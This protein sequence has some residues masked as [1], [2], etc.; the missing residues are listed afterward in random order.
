MPR[1]Q[2]NKEYNTFVQGLITEASP[3]TFPE[4]ASKDEA[5]FILNRNGSRRRRQGMDYESSYSL[6]PAIDN[7]VFTDKYTTNHVWR[8]AANSG[9]N[10]FSVV[11]AGDTLYFYDLNQSALSFNRK[12][13]TVDLNTYK[14]TSATN[15]GSNPIFT[16]SGKGILFV[17][18]QD[19]EPF[20]IEY[21]PVAD[22]IS[23]AQINIK[24]RDFLGIDDGL[25]DD[26]NPS[27][28]LSA[29][30]NY[31]L[32][33]QGWTS[34]HITTY[35]TATSTSPSNSQVWWNGKNS[36]GVFNATD[37]DEIYF[38]NT[39][40]PKGHFIIDLFNRDRDTVS[41]VTGVTT[42]TEN[43]R[44]SAVAFYAGRAFYSGIQS[45]QDG[46]PSLNGYILFS[47]IIEDVDKIG[48]CYQS[49]DPTSEVV[50]DLIATDGGV[51]VIPEVGIIKR[52]EPVRDSLVI[53][54]DNGVWQLKGDTDAG[55]TADA[56]NVTKITNIG[57]INSQSIVT[58][59][60]TVFYWS[61][62]GIYALAPDNVTGYLRA[63]N[64]TETTI[65]SLYQTI[66][67]A[68]R[69]NCTGVYDPISKR[70]SWLY[71][72]NS[73]YVGGSEV[74]KYN[75]ELVFDVVLQAF[76]K[77]TISSLA[78]RS[79][80][81]AGYVLTPNLIRSDISYN[82]VDESGNLITDESLV[83]V[84]VDV[85][86]PTIGSTSIKYLT[87]VPQSD[88]TNSKLTYSLYTNSD[89]YDWKTA[90]NTGVNFV[91]YLWTGHELLQDSQRSKQITYL[92]THFTRTETGFTTSGTDLVLENPSGCY[93]Q[94]RWEF[95]DSENSGRW[96]SKLQAYRFNRNYI[97][98]GSGDTFD[99]GF[100]VIT[101]KNK[102]RGHGRAISLYFE[103]EEGKDCEILGWAISVTGSTIT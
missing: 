5:N 62:G 50:S 42:E 88:D 29:E 26:E 23:T 60:G 54:A 37:L 51:I 39:P 86:T 24:I 9:L 20:Y 3:L 76:Y 4:N 16:A 18:S 32:L 91:S 19:T 31:N 69:I 66:S 92:T 6:G 25:A 85:E 21:N 98:S 71:N 10:N 46:G 65:Q 53:F 44:P 99:Y 22:T 74:N 102:V 2:A 101:T 14:K 96:G 30:H 77:N 64:I 13:F 61:D 33:N 90:D 95:S 48:K 55:F 80:Y 17:V 28:P 47:Q 58:A 57:A 82:L 49:A 34:T 100:S 84:V 75:A 68:A 40:A 45:D 94:T 83:Q 103:S 59:E 43:G 78:S 15:L 27:T 35:E 63:Q 41:G 11:Q 38:G 12:A 97:P 79:P 89:F 8:N 52:L 7:S 70:I 73:S 81:V 36:S 72:N 87:V 56:F 67:S 1:A 93:Y